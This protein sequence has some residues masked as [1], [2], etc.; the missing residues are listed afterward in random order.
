MSSID[1]IKRFLLDQKES[2]SIGKADIIRVAEAL[3][4]V[5]EVIIERNEKMSG[6]VKTF[7][8][9]T[10]RDV[11]AMLDLTAEKIE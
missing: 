4:R 6:E 7:T 8:D 1:K 2:D 10:F 11:E 3:L 5:C 9:R